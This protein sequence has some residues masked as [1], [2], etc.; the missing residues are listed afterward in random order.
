MKGIAS[1]LVLLFG[2]ALV[3]AEE[4]STFNAYVD[5]DIC[6]R[7]MLGPINAS[8][9]ECSQKTHKDGSNPV[10][11]NLS[12]NALFGVDKQK[13]INKL[14]GTLAEVSGEVKVKDGRMKLKEVKPIEAGSIPQGDPSRKLLDV[15]TYRTPNGPRV[16]EAIRHELAM[17]PYITEFDFISFTMVGSDVLLTGWTVRSSNRSTAENL[18][19][20]VEGVERV[21]NNIEILPLGRTDMQL[22]AGARAALQRFLSRYFWGSGSDIKIIV[23]NGNIILLGTVATQSDSDTAS[24][25]CRSLP[26]SF[27]VFNMLRVSGAE[28]EQKKG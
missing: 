25:Q 28:N 13:M 26:F 22:R 5:S 8:R 21:I 6:A 2:G 11:V 4:I 18:V 10:L 27:H 12:N 23:K 1:I 24:I 15:R 17:M 3:H 16:F 7:L 9:I 20:N 14:V 19:R